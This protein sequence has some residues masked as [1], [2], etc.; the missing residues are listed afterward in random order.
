MTWDGAGTHNRIHN[1]SA[2]ASAGIQAQAVRFDAEFDD[3][4]T[5][6]ENCQTLTGETTPTANSPMGGFRHTG[7]AA[8]TSAAEYLRADQSSNQVGIYIRDTNT[9]A[10]G[11]ISGSAAVFPTA[12]TDG[13]RVSVKVSADGSTSAPRAIIINGLSANIIDNKGSAVD[14]IRMVS[15]GTYDLVYN[16]SASAFVCLTLGD[17]QVGTFTGTLTGCTTSP[18]EA[19]RYA[20]SGEKVT[21]IWESAQQGTS[22]TNACT[23]TGMPQQ[24]WP[25]TAQGYIVFSVQNN[26]T[27]VMARAGIATTGVITFGRILSAGDGLINSVWTTSGTKGPDANLSIHYDLN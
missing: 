1:F 2:D 16:A 9:T 18:T 14:A 17:T 19:I 10:T 21:L 11:T 12:F 23:V 3:I 25:T 22:N 15:T 5:A 20:R 4:S 8:A 26:G 7:V 24:L 27:A 6:L 13:Q